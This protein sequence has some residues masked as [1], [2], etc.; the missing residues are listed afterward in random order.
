VIPG[1]AE[2]FRRTWGAAA[3]VVASAPGR[4]NLIGEHTDY[5]G[6][7]VLPFALEQRTSVAAGAVAGGGWEAV[8]AMDG[9]R[10]AVA[11]GGRLPR[12]WPAYLV[13]VAR[14]F[15]GLGV[16]L[17]S[18][19]R[20]AVDSSVP[21]G[22]GLSSS[23]ALTVALVRALASLAAV[24]LTRAT[25]AELAYR[26]EHDHV[27]VRCGRMDQTI[28]AFG[29]QG[30]ALLIETATGARRQLP[31]ARPVLLVDTGRTHRLSAG[32]LN[33]RRAECE[34][35]LARILAWRSGTRALAELDPD[36]LGD[37]ARRLP[38]VLARRVRH[39]VTETARTRL[40]A[41]ALAQNRLRRAGE[42]LLEGH[43]SLRDD[44][45]SSCAEADA[46]VTWAVDAGAWGA[47][48]TGAG[49]GG[50][51]LVLAPDRVLPAVRRDVAEQF[52]R[53]FGAAPR[54]WIAHASSGVRM[55]RFR[56]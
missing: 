37:V 26:A 38:R 4:A 6:G 30:H 12:G 35:A 2:L 53:R 54:S 24:R 33:E 36:D 16:T 3:E 49:W 56:R 23:A 8:S 48:L 47:R 15:R 25:I 44:F 42:L 7:P 46:V 43:A 40:A 5:N 13:G 28:A 39:V 18:G 19:V 32:A 51:V 50:V 45:A 14:A 29:K 31:F 10:H 1:A 41:A 21:T 22:A 20:V 27:G 9:V 11:P 34:Q 55:E 17:P 52:A